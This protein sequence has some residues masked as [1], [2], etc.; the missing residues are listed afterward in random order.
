MIVQIYEIQTPQE[1]ERLVELGV[2][3][4]GSVIAERDNLKDPLVLQTVQTAQNAGSKSSLIPL[5]SD[6]DMIARM[7]DCYRPDIVHLC[8]A[9]GLTGRDLS[10]GRLSAQVERVCDGLAGLQRRIKESFPG[11]AL[12]RSVPIPA[13]GKARPDVILEIAGRFEP[14]SDFFLTDTLILPDTPLPSDLAGSQPVSGFVGI[15]GKICD[16]SI[17]AGLIRA[18]SIPVILAGGI[19]P[20]NVREGI[21]R[22]NPA[23]VDS[24]TA[25]NAAGPDGKP[26][27]FSKDMERVK[28]LIELARNTELEKHR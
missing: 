10:G 28:R 3:H 2:D 21:E 14:V 4:I 13:P 17:A 24:C 15:T 23:G 26:V 27:R 22:T 18:S 19:S 12:M 20:E 25:T 16:W 11:I 6:F 8:E 5:F 9:L 1:A 7:I